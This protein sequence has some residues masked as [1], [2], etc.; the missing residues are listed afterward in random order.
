MLGM[1]VSSLPRNC[2]RRAWRCLWD[3]GCGT[4]VQWAAVAAVDTFWSRH[5]GEN[6]MSQISNWAVFAI[7]VSGLLLLEM[8]LLRS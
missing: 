8:F 7:G 4:K 2:S 3:L 1:L 5:G 6:E